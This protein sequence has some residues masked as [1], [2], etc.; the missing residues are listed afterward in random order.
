MVIVIAMIAIFAGFATPHIHSWLVQRGLNTAVDQL[1]GDMQRAR[2]LA[3]KQ[4]LNCD[5]T[6]NS[7]AVDK[8]TISL[9]NQV[10]DLGQYLG[11]VTFKAPSTGVITFTPWGTCTAGQIRLSNQA[12]TMSYRLETSGAGGISKQFWDGTNWVA[13]GI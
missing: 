11:K 13:T 3:I 5:L 12:N 1:Q 9:S 4:H 2:L 7:P 6:I 8:Y 10:V